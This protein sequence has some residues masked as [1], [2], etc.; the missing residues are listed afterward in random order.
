M[1]RQ[2]SLPSQQQP[3]TFPYPGLEQS[4]PCLPTLLLEYPF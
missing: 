3:A 2:G 4:S 1:E